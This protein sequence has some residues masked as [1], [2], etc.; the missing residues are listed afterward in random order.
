MFR[1]KPVQVRKPQQTEKANGIFILFCCKKNYFNF[2][3]LEEFF[4][5]MHSPN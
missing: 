3:K 4:D 5:K 1:T 2:S